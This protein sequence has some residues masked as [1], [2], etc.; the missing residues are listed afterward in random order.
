MRNLMETRV[1]MRGAGERK[2]GEFGEVSA[3]GEICLML[4]CIHSWSPINMEYYF[5]A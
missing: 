1:V 3:A 2:R 4:C 5:S